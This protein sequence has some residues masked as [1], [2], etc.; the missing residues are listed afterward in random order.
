[1]KPKIVEEILHGLEAGFILGPFSPTSPWALE[2]IVCPLGVVDKKNGKYRVIQDLSFGKRINRSVN[3]FIPPAA[4]AVRYIKTH[5]IV[6][7]IASLGKGAYLWVADMAEAYRRVLL[8]PAFSKYL[9]F[10]W[11][12]KVFRY[13]CLPFGLSSSP[14]IYSRFAEC[15]RQIVLLSNGDLY[16]Y[17][18]LATILNYLDDFFGGHPNKPTAIKQYLLFRQWLLYLGIPTQDTKCSWPN[19]TAIILGFLYNTITQTLSIPTKKQSKILASL[20]PFLHKGNLF[21]RRQIAQLVGKLN[22]VSIIIFGGRTMLRSLEW[23]IDISTHWDHECIR[24]TSEQRK[25]ILWWQQILLSQYVSMPFSHFLRSANLTDIHVWSDASGS[26][27]LGF[28]A[29]NS[30][31]YY[32]QIRW[33]DIKLPQPWIWTDINRP[34]LLAMVVAAVVWAPLFSNRSVTFHC[35]NSSVV[36]QVISRSIPKWRPDLLHLTRWLTQV[37]LKNRFYFWIQFIPGESNVEADNLS[38]FLPMP[39]ERLLLKETIDKYTSPFFTFQPNYSKIF[40][41]KQTEAK[42]T[43]LECLFKDPIVSCP[44]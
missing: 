17:Q 15:L 10:S 36:A 29:Y 44:L 27:K 13:T 23:S 5:E 33:K 8:H 16:L 2:T 4:T 9:G 26:Q 39:F 7:V 34:E 19:T 38:R 42:T 30:L 40:N 24:L 6:R 20:R 21:S 18:G 41:W 35:D 43:A 32:F 25:D 37:A 28:A 3:W 12:G 14:A 11:E 31:G 1:M 22:W